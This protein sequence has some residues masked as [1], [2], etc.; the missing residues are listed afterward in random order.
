MTGAVHEPLTEVPTI[1]LEPGER[2]KRGRRLLLGRR[3]ARKRSNLAVG[4]AAAWVGALLL[5]A[6]FVHWLPLADP[7]SIV[8]P[9]NMS[10]NFSKE[11]LGTDGIGRSELSR[12]AFGARAS[13]GISIMACAIALV[14]GAVIGIVTA[15]FGWW[16]TAIVDV[17]ANAILAV[18]AL[19]LLLAIVLALQPSMLVLTLALALTFIPKFLLLTRAHARTELSH[20]YVLSAQFL[21]AGTPR[22]MFR[23]VLPNSFTPLIS[24][25][26]LVIPSLIVTEGSLSFLGHG[27]PAPTPSWGAMIAQAQPFLAQYPA[28]VFIPCIALFFTVFALNILGDALRVKLDVRE[29]QL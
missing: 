17:V 14:L 7:G 3:K 13:L 1:S 24:Y 11:F 10:P 2:R 27:I 23:E 19:L 26:A 18:P 12:L 6:L 28:A 21:G 22:V 16:L 15:Y 29:G 25:G 9:P 5:V 8:G 20:D 4:I